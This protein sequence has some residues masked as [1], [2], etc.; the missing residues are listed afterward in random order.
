MQKKFSSFAPSDYIKEK[1]TVEICA[2]HFLGLISKIHK[3]M[4][5]A[6]LNNRP[7]LG[8][9]LLQKIPW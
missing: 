2:K 6:K 7:S 9:R 5:F 3:S 8:D 1:L 4:A